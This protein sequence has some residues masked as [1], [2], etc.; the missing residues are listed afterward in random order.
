MILVEV[1]DKCITIKGHACYADYGEDIVCA[2]VSS[3]VITSVNGCLSIDMDSLDYDMYQD[4]LKIVILSEKES[5]KAIMQNMILML[6][7][8]EKQYKENI[9]V[10]EKG[11]PLFMRLDVEEEV[12]YIREGMK[13]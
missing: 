1:S 4:E 12:N 11:E 9:K 13:K 10:I 6:K 8:L 5:I 7:D 2:S 3:I